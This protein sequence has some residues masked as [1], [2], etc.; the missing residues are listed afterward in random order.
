MLY[1][2]ITFKKHFVD[3]LKELLIINNLWEQKLT[4]QLKI[5]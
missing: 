3:H 2:K 4:I 5:K 1:C